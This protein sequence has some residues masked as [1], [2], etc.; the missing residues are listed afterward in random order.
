MNVT[1]PEKFKLS[2]KQKIIFGTIILICIIAVIV[3]FYIQFYARVDFAE[4]IG[5]SEKQVDIGN[6]SDEDIEKIK[7]NFDTI[8]IN[9]MKDVPED[10]LDKRADKS[11]DIVYTKSEILEN[12]SNSYDINVNIPYINVDN[13]IINSYNEE[14]KNNFENLV[15]RIMNTKERN[16]IYSVEYVASV[17]DDILSLMIR[18]N[19]KQSASAQ[20]MMIQTYNYDLRNNKEVSLKELLDIEGLD[21]GIAQN[22]INDEISTAQKRVEALKGLGYTVYSR[23]LNDKMYKVENTTEFYMSNDTL[24][25]IYAYGNNNQTSENDIVVL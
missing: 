1:L 7:A 14:I 11:K 18:S 19:L 17:K 12:E 3:S 5:F 23:D 24:Y 10:T 22:K 13:K 8:F 15:N 25:I 21:I 20:R 16:I 4:L 9:G 2:I 6:K